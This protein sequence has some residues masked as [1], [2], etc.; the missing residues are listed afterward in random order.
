[1]I[2]FV[3]T[4]FLCLSFV[5]SAPDGT[6]RYEFHVP[7]N[8][9]IQCGSG[10]SKELE[11]KLNRLE[12]QVLIAQQRTTSMHETLSN[13]ITKLYRDTETSKSTNGQIESQL[14]QMHAAIKSAEYLNEEVHGL[15]NMLMNTSGTLNSRFQ[16]LQNKMI[17]VIGQVQNQSGSAVSFATLKQQLTDQ[18]T[19]FQSQVTRMTQLERDVQ[20]ANALRQEMEAMKSANEQT[21]KDIANLKETLNGLVVEPSLPD[22]VRR[23][24]GSINLLQGMII[25]GLRN[26]GQKIQ[27]LT[28]EME[29]AK[30]MIN[31]L[32]ANNRN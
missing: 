10:S 22:A 16:D 4:L 2:F 25:N 7:D 27:N 3:V 19:R 6:C 18:E 13:E 12:N 14:I 28:T 20:S 21:I 30:E 17:D 1:M 8:S 23:L 9:G 26:D 5:T 11:Y 29:N 32:K 31:S 15:K 24:K